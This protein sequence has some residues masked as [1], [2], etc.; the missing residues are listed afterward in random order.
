[1]APSPDCTRTSQVRKLP[2]LDG[3]GS[4]AEYQQALQQR[5]LAL[6]AEPNYQPPVLPVT[7]MKLL[8]LSQK[9][10]TS[11][12]D[13][14]TVLEIDP[15]LTADVLRLAQSVAFSNGREPKSIN[16]CITRIGLRRAGDLFLRAALDATIFRAPG[17]EPVLERLRRHSVVTGEIARM[18]CKLAQLDDNYAYMCGLLHD[19]GIA[20]A[21]IAIGGRPGAASPIEFKTLWPVL[22]SIHAQF[23]IQLAMLW[24]LPTE[25]R[26]ILQHHH[27]FAIEGSPNPMAAVTILAEIIAAGIG[28]GFEGEES[29]YLLSKAV[30]SLN[31]NVSELEAI[32]ARARAQLA[33]A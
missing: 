32:E 20:G 16:D 7:A 30:E 5:L 9:V 25:L 13:L 22:S 3:A 33:P 2:D 28:A 24:N 15:V 12:S 18:I 29:T 27:T 19:V 11:I 26:T 1:M 31:L 14:V 17:Y 4:L 21:I 23:T 8:R 10:E 6:F